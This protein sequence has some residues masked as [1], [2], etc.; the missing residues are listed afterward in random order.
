MR[1]RI[2]AAALTPLCAASAAAD[3]EVVGTLTALLLSRVSCSAP[4]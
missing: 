4:C 2:P 1:S 3:D